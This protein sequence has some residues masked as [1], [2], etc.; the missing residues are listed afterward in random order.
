MNTRTLVTLSFTSLFSVSAFAASEDGLASTPAEN[1]AA[2]HAIPDRYIVELKPG[3]DAGAVAPAHGVAPNFIYRKAVNGFAGHVP[4]GRLKN[5][6]S[7]PRVVRVVP[8]RTVSA[9]GKP[10]AG[11]T[12]TGQV[13]PEG[14]RRI[15]AGPGSTNYSGAGVGIAVVDTGVDFNHADLQP[16]GAASFSAFAGTAQDNNGHGTHVAGTIAAR[17]NTIDVVGAAPAATLYG[18][19]VLDAA[20]SGSDSGVTAGLEWILANAALVTPPIRV[21]NMSLGR[22][23]T[24]NDNPIQRAA[25]QNLVANGITVIVAAGNDSSLEVSQQVPSTYPEVISVASTTAKAGTNA[26]R[27]FNGFINADT[28]SYFTSDGAYNITT[29]IGVSI[30]APGETQENINKMGSVLSV[31]ILSTKLG[32]GTTAMSGTSMAAPHAAGVAAL[33]WQKAILFGQALTSEQVRA[34][35]RNGA[36]NFSAPFDSPT[37][38]YSYDGAREGVLS[39]P[40]AL[41]Q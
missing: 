41:A 34:S 6:T 12:S 38:G 3:V 11:G 30:S 13:V 9:V 18:V 15:G 22:V 10:S 35:I 27:L 29:G 39:A 14:I 28:A 4:P 37:T 17:H 16:L 31:G 1:A 24:L 23:G 40:G 8:D 25:I 5:L 32:G 26:Y 21:V 33:L 2:G 19:K 7:D 20:G 36:T